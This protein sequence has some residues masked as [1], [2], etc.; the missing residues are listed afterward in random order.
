MIPC[1]FIN[2]SKKTKERVF[3]PFFTTKEVGKGTGLGIPIAR[4]IIEEKHGGNFE[5]KEFYNFRKLML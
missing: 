4:Q 3:D 1:F 2:M 5:Q